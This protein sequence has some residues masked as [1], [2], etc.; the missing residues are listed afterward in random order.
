MHRFSQYIAESQLDQLVALYAPDALF[1]PQPGVEHRGHAAI[2]GALSALLELSPQMEARVAEVHLAGDTAL[3][4]VDWTLQGTAPDG[5][6]VSQNGRSADV[7]RR[8]NDG[9]WR[10]LIDHP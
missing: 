8:D 2:R 4:V 9:T 3:V 5:S 6:A 7:L 10:V 1:V